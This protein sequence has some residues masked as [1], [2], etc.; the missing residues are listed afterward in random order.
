MVQ[1][2]RIGETAEEQEEDDSHVLDQIENKQLPSSVIAQCICAM[3]CSHQKKLEMIAKEGTQQPFD[4][5]GLDDDEREQYMA[6]QHTTHFSDNKHHDN[7]IDGMEVDIGTDIDWTQLRYEGERN[8][9]IEGEDWID[10]AKS[11][12]YNFL[13][14]QASS[15]SRNDLVIPKQTNGKIYCVDGSDEQEKIV[16]T[17]LDTIIKFLNNDPSYKPLRATVMGCGGAGKSHVIN[18]IISLVRKLTSC[19][20]TVQ[21]A[22]PSG[23]AAYNVQGSTIHRLLKI[24]VRNPENKLPTKHQDLLKQQLLRLLVLIIDERSQVNSKVLA[25]SERNVRECIYGGQ[26]QKAR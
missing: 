16:Y 3:K 12:Y 6:F 13:S 9:Q 10:Y 18:T 22:A 23:S 1:R 24:G 19:N 7:I 21:V 8:V 5:R 4:L 2:K 20:D 11:T 25:A 26:N 17:V 14:K 15:S